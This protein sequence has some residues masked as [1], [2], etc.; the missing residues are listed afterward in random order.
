MKIISPF[1][2]GFLDYF[3]VALFAIAPIV[4]SFAE[5][6]KLICFALA[7]VHLVTTLLTAF[8]LGVAALIPFP[9]HGWMERV[10]GPVLVALPFV[11]GFAGL[12]VWFFV[13]AGVTI[14]LVALVT[15][16]HAA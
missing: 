9:I 2:H 3:T 4:L 1:I 5:L 6:P 12:A 11:L 7:A 10:I 8:P 13:A 16:Y 14:V 15:D